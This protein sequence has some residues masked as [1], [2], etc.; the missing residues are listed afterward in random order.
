MEKRKFIKDIFD[1]IY[2]VS[3]NSFNE[4][5]KLMEYESFSKGEIFVEKNKTNRKEY[6]V[7][8]GICKSFLINPKGE[9][10]TLTFFEEKSVLS[11]NSSRTYKGISILN[12]QALTN[13]RLASINSDKFEEMMIQN[14]EIRNLGY[15]IMI[16]ELAQKADKE[17]SMASLTAKER[18]IKLRKQ[19]PMLE[20]L[21]PHND[22]ATYLGITNISLSRLRRNLVK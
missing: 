16:H 2:P 5:Y 11:P 14:V 12:F 10:T 21:I 3:E 6:F 7:I 20:N 4:I 18:L 1:S 17:V 9:N 8:E 15:T 13:L 19:H 22:I